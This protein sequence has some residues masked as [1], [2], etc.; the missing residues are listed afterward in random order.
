M[1]NDQFQSP[2][3]ARHRSQHIITK[4]L[5]EDA[6]AAQHGIAPEAPSQNF[7]LDAPA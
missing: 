5:G 1:M 2:C 4:S 6:T 7:E 3:P